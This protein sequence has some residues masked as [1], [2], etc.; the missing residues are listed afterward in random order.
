MMAKDMTPDKHKIESEKRAGQREAAKHHML[1]AR[2]DEERRQETERHL[3]P[4]ALANSE[5][6]TGNAAVRAVMLMKQEAC[7]SCDGARKELWRLV[8]VG[9]V[10]PCAW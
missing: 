2:V 3:A 6:L 1:T 10:S 7:Y 9:A 5:E 8:D 4:Q